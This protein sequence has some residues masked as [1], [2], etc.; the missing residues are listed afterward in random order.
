MPNS[1][2][3]YNSGFFCSFTRIISH[4]FYYNLVIYEIVFYKPHFYFVCVSIYLHVCMCTSCVPSVRTG[5]QRAPGSLEPELQMSVNCHR[6]QPAGS[7][8]K[9]ASAFNV[10]AISPVPGTFYSQ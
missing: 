3:A 4:C 10:R 7:S 1:W 8:A 6:V 2:F 9:A 5:Q